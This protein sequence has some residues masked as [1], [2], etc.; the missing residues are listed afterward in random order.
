MAR[1]PK[2][3]AEIQEPT[4]KKKGNPNLK[5]DDMGNIPRGRVSY[6][7]MNGASER[8]KK[9]AKIRGIPLYK[10]GEM[11]GSTSKNVFLNK[12]HRD[13]MGFAEVEEI[14]DL[15]DFDVVFRDRRTGKIF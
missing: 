11:H 4:P 7:G 10:L 5:N 15:L 8:I 9:A 13:R 2:V 1:K 12:L 14:A 6:I 3:E